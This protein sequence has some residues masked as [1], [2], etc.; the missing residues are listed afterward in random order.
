MRILAVH[1]LYQIRGGEDECYDAE[2]KLLREAGHHVDRY[3]ETNDRIATLSKTQV[4]I[5][6][7]WSQEAYETV[8]QHLTQQPYDAVHV[9]NFFP[10]I[11]PSVYYAAHE[12]G[13]PIV[14]TLHNYRL[15]CPNA[16]FF[17]D[18]N[19]CEDCIGKAVPYPGAVHSCYR[20][21][22]TASAGVMAM[23][24][25]HTA[26]GTWFNRVDR[27][28]ALTEF[29]RQ[30]FIEGGLP[31][32]KILVKPNFVDPDPG[33]GGGQG[34]YALYVGRLSVEKG[35]DTLLA[36][37]E[38]LQHPLPL[39]IVGD[40]PLSAEV[41]EAT[42]RLPHV[43]WLGRKPMAE[44]HALMGDALCLVFPS[45][46]YETFGRVAIESFA[47]GTPVV[48]SNI[49]AIAELVK[50][51]RTG[52]LFEPANPQ[53]L[54]A[55]VEDLL[56]NPVRLAQ[57]RR[58]ARAEFEAKYTTQKNYEQLIDIYTKAQTV[59]MAL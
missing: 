33:I 14:Q 18:G 59:P 36:A 30:K 10:L 8:K 13:V 23:L 12:Q 5:K 19:V 39:K 38:R 41:I 52:L 26:K 1:N 16:L 49:G 27:Y 22:R 31:A 32:H 45:K 2:V 53:D 3:V 51:G 35:L 47:K 44:V 28:I 15:L 7:I 29:A 4:A 50:S 17:R 9:H 21:S 54:A 56:S 57:M 25:F 20:E 34:G 43:T 40:G 6:T 11:S 48:A 37:W 24:A 46:W 55:K 42:R 58:E